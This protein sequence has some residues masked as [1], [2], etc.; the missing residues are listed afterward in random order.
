MVFR[1][2]GSLRIYHIGGVGCGTALKNTWKLELVSR[3]IPFEALEEVHI[4]CFDFWS[5]MSAHMNLLLCKLLTFFHKLSPFNASPDLLFVGEM[6]LTRKRLVK[7]CSKVVVSMRVLPPHEK[8]FYAV[9]F[10]IPESLKDFAGT[11]IYPNDLVAKRRIG[12]SHLL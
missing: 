9:S 3:T 4:Q 12:G 2:D 7:T 5:Q 10:Q 6:L 11:F 1:G 8:Q